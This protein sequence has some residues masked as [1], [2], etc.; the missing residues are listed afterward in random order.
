[1]EFKNIKE[2]TYYASLLEYLDIGSE[3]ICYLNKG[4]KKVYKLF[5]DY[6][7]KDY[8]CKYDEDKLD[9]LK[10]VKCDSFVWPTEVIK[11]DDKIVGYTVP[12]IHAKSLY[13][14]D[15]L[16]V[17]LDLLTKNITLVRKDIKQLSNNNIIMIDTFYNILYSKKFY[18]ID[19]DN[20]EINKDDNMDVLK[21]N[22][23]TFDTG[24]YNYLIKHTFEE[25]VSS[26]KE[27]REL[28]QEKKED[29]LVFIELFRKKINELMGT[30]IKYLKDAKTLGDKKIIS[31][32]IERF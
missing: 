10:K 21:E 20:Y 8:I 28:Y 31:K 30:E 2:L 27:L 26:D 1:M 15:L 4:Q 18:F 25:L 22:N 5:H 32:G 17:N 9:K 24:I 7:E 6:E 13:D 16:S 29:I 12:Y 14:I 3:G 11:V 19:A 23:K